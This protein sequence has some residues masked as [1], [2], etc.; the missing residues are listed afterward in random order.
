[1][2]HQGVV[3][4]SGTPEEIRNNERVKDAVFGPTHA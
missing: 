4:A 3:L 1:V 2:M